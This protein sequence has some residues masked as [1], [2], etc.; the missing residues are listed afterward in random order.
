M[1]D[2]LNPIYT[3]ERQDVFIS[4]QR[5][6]EFDHIVWIVDESIRGD[7][8]QINNPI[9]KTTPFLNSI[10]DKQIS[11]FGVSCSAA[12]CSDYS[13][14]I[15]FSGARLDQLP[16]TKDIIRK[17]PSIFQY[18]KK[19]GFEPALIYSP[20]YEDKP[21]S[22]LTSDDFRIIQ[23]RY[24]TKMLNPELT[25][26]AWDFR[27]LD[28]LKEIIESND[29]SFTYFLKYGAHFHYDDAYPLSNTVFKPTIGFRNYSKVDSTSLINSY[30]NAIRWTVDEFF[31]KLFDHI[32]HKKVLIIYTSDHGQN[33]TE[34]PDLEL[35]HCARKEA[36]KVMANVPLFI[37]M[38]D[39]L[40]KEIIEG[41]R[42]VDSGF[43][44]HYNIF[45]TT[46]LL[47]G[48]QGDE[49][50]QHYEKSLFDSVDS[51]SYTSGDIFGR[52]EMYK[53]QFKVN[54]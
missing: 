6:S 20:G 15:L 52:S 39:T 40:S 33:L 26:E 5:D 53:Y 1:Y 19:A 17:N 9:L 22:Y 14:A 8:L 46:L 24:N 27:S 34:Y 18:A 48:Y 21:K 23:T 30:H 28:Y 2:C 41:R 7:H 32:G 31:R 35:T 43:Y 42:I 29:Q 47:M 3:G 54:D 13:H 25:Y 10:E 37:C 44:S 49:I 36:P 4:P 51:S 45:S 11:N 12:V 50:N 16:D 38:T